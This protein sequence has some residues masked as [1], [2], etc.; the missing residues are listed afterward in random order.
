MVA[1]FLLYFSRNIIIPEQKFIILL[2]KYLVE[3][4]RG[5]SAK[6]FWEYINGQLFALYGVGRGL[7]QRVLARIWQNLGVGGGG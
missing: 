6:S 2:R 4:R 7:V 3:I 1:P 5:G